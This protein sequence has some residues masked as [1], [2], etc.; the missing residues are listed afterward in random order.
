MWIFNVDSNKWIKQTD[1]ITQDNYN[2]IKQDI[3]STKLYSKALSGAVYLSISDTNNIYEPL[4]YQNY[5]SWYIDSNSSIYA[6]SSVPSNGISISNTSI[7]DYN[8]Y[9]YEYGFSLKNSFTPE[10]AIKYTNFIQADIATTEQIDINNVVTIDGVK[11]IDGMTILV[12]D[13]TTIVDLSVSVDPST[14]FTGNYY[15]VNNNITDISYSYYNNQ[16]GIYTYTNNSLI[17]STASNYEYYS[18]L[19]VYIKNGIVNFDKQF[20]LSRLLNGYYPT[21]TDPLEFLNKHNYLIRH[22]VDYHDLYETNYYDVIRHDTQLYNIL[23]LTYTVPNRLLYAGDFG[24]IIMKQNNSISQSTYLYNEYKDNIKTL[25]EN[26]LYYW[27]CGDNGLL[28]KISKIDL[29]I[30]KIDLPNEYNTLTS[31]SFINDLRGIVVGKY[32]TIYYTFDGGITWLKL[33]FTTDI[34]YS[35]NKVIYYSYNTIYI[36]GETGIFLELN[37]SDVTK[38]S[39]TKR[40][41]YKNLT[42]TDQYELVED[43][44]DMQYIGYTASTWNLNYSA[45]GY[46]INPIKD[47]LFLTTNNNNIIIYEINTFVPEHNYLYLVFSQSIGDITSI[48]QQHNTTN[49]VVS[50]DNTIIF[51]INTFATVST[52]SNLIIGTTYSILHSDYSNKIFDYNGQDLY[53]VGNFSLIKDYNY[54]TTT[55]A[56]VSTIDTKSKLLV[57]DYDIADKLNFFDSNY[58]YRLPNSI[59]FSGITVSSIAFGTTQSTWLDYL[60]NNY[61]SPTINS[62]YTTYSNLNNTFYI[63]TNSCTFSNSAITINY[64]DING[65]YPI[66]GSHTQSRFDSFVPMPN[67]SYSVFLYDYI[68]IFNLGSDFCVVGDVLQIAT[69]TITSN[70][71]VNYQY[72]TYSYA[73]NDFNQTMIQSIKDSNVLYVSN[74]NKYNDYEELTQNYALHP[75]SDGYQLTY[76]TASTIYSI[77]PLFNATT[78]YKYLTTDIT[79]NSDSIANTYAIDYATSY[80]QFGYTANY[81]ILDYLSNV[82]SVFNDSKIFNS[83]PVYYNLPGNGGSSFLPTNIY[84]DISAE[85]TYSNTRNKLYFGADLSYE[86][87][88]IW[89]N[90]FVDIT[91]HTTHGD[92]TSNQIL[93]VDKYDGII[94]GVACYVIEFAYSILDYAYPVNTI[95]IISR[96]TLGDIS[97]DLKLLN[98]LNK[99]LIGEYY[100]N[101]AK[102]KVSTESYTK[103]FLTDGDIKK[104]ITSV[105]YTNDNF[106]LSLNVIN[107]NTTTTI[108]FTDSFSYSSDLAVIT[109]DLSR[110]NTGDLVYTNFTGGSQSSQ[111]LNT[112]YIGIHAVTPIDSINLN[113]NIPYLN[114]PSVLDAGYITAFKFDPAF[115]YYPLSI[116]DIGVDSMYK[117]PVELYHSNIQKNGVV[118]SLVNYNLNKPIFRLIDGLDI[119][120]I[121]TKFHWILE[122]EITNAIIGADINGLVWYSGIWKSGRA[123]SLKFL[124]G[125]WL[126]GDFYDGQFHSRNVIDNVT[127]VNVGTTENI[128][129]SYWYNGRAFNTDYYSVIW[130]NGR[131]Y[132]STYNNCR[133]FNG[134]NSDGAITSQSI[135]YGGIYLN[136]LVDNSIINSL[137]K[138]SYCINMKFRSGEIQQCQYFSG[139][140]G[141]DKRFTSKFGN[142]ASNS[143]MA[144]FENGTLNGNIYSFEDVNGLSSTI[145]K[146]TV[147][148]TANIRGSVYGG[149]FYAI[150]IEG[151]VNWKSGII[152]DIEVIGVIPSLNQI[153][154]NG[155]FRFQIGDF[156]NIISSQP[157]TYSGLG[158]NDS[159]GRYKID[160]VNFDYTLN[161]T[162]LTLNY[163]LSNIPGF[164]ITPIYN[165]NTKLRVVSKITNIYLENG[166]CKNAWVE[167]CTIKNI[168]WYNGIM[169]NCHNGIDI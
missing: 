25:I 12:K 125:T 23:G 119:N 2:L 106:D 109:S 34:I 52:T 97:N 16:N 20:S 146:F 28:L 118:A 91:L 141:T 144:I 115:N 90:T 160:L 124:S 148:K 17:K 6:S 128:G 70:L 11:L 87:N 72:G 74:L 14:Y 35:Y 58:D 1:I 75:I 129:V 156:V 93:I 8:K 44:N 145:H 49:I 111:Y 161:T 67:G 149:I 163:V 80:K 33:N 38:W 27:A 121:S 51:D 54:G 29:S 168:M 41:I 48:T 62:N 162:I 151:S 5:K 53:N 73:F 78:A 37:Y 138:P 150:N 83:M 88:T 61:K 47:C 59:T 116:L 100:D 42:L 136:S 122:A 36:G 65:L 69:D 154:L 139:N 155:I 19:S 105:L 7:I 57:V 153:T 24:T 50:A 108:P 107:I 164:P 165:T 39:L 98:T 99:P 120:Q 103:I 77:S 43:I 31:I 126:S 169:K 166:V 135:L 21:Y 82:N 10:T 18:G 152:L 26:G 132:Q 157:T 45:T 113:I 112:S 22:Q 137:N 147:I 85:G 133:W 79:I 143:R 40:T 56:T 76:D 13:Q 4:Q 81:N 167:N 159:P 140:F 96:N 60:Y 127:T 30:I 130:L 46:G 71:I 94:D 68:S 84:F 158:T 9:L 131:S 95:D 3:A 66:I 142:L 110:V 92:I 123:F 89:K 63:G 32:N 102:T 64:A 104:Y 86:Y 114:T 101:Y 15:I 117:I 134:I 55:Y